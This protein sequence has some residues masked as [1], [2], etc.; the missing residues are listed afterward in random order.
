MEKRKHQTSSRQQRGPAGSGSFFRSV[1]H[2]TGK[3]LFSVVRFFKWQLDHLIS[4]KQRLYLRQIIFRSDTPQGKRFDTILIMLIGASVIAVM[5]ETVSEF[6]QS[7][8]W[9]FFVLEWLFTIL[10]TVE[11]ILRIYSARNPAGY[12]TSFFGVVD[13]LAILPTYISVF[14]MGTQHLLIVRALRLLRIFR[15][16]KMG[17]FVKEGAI[18]ISALQASRTKIYV[19]ISFVVLMAII[20]G[21]LMYMVEFPH[22][23]AFS[24]IPAGIYWAIVTLTT[25]GYGDVTPVSAFGKFLATLVMILGYGVIAVPTGIVTA[26]ISGRVM[27][28]KDFEYRECQRCG[29]TEHHVGAQ[30]CHRCGARL[31]DS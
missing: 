22:N 26:E 19:F 2:W 23:P 11:Y 31:S 25:V 30:H 10:F 6:H 13:L 8:W 4:V 15:I 9:V 18:V 16:F 17:H 3:L 29:Q 24:N 7:N 21:A 28:L 1:L 14:F 5:L 27:N 12:A 20:I